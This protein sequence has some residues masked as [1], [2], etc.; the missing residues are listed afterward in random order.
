MFGAFSTVLPVSY[1]VSNLLEDRTP[2]TCT[3][4]GPPQILSSTLSIIRLG[5]HRSE[6]MILRVPGTQFRV[7]IEVYS[8][9][10]SNPTGRSPFGVHDT[11]S[12]QFRVMI[13]VYSIV[14]E[15]DWA[16]TV[17]CT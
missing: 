4:R 2:A 15:S 13:E 1:G 7:M 17:R 5:A 8:I 9:V 11:P 10:L 3:E 16:L 12:T 14:L 6:Y